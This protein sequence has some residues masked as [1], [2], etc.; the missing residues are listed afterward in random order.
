MANHKDEMFD[1]EIW[2]KYRATQDICLRNKILDNYLYIATVNAKRMS[3]IYRSKAELE[4]VVNECVLA[5]IDCIEKFDPERG[6]QFDTYASIRIRGAIIDFM[7]KQDW[8]PREVRKR[9]MQIEDTYAELQAELGRNP[10]DEEVAE[11]MD[12]TIDEFRQLISQAQRFSVLSYEELLDS[13]YNLQDRESSIKA[14]EQT[15]QEEEIKSVLATSIDSLKEKER[16]IISLHYFEELKLREIA[17]IL[18]L[19]PSRV[20]QIHTTALMK[21]EKYLQNYLQG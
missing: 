10:N 13:A 20:S 17:V 7:R 1:N 18:N 9:S 16:L 11:Q 15:I 14:P 4:D 2:L 6:V 5:L 19:T 12:L 21:M 3:S 8:V